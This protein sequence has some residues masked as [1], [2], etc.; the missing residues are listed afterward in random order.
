MDNTNIQRSR[1]LESETRFFQLYILCSFAFSIF[2]L[3]ITVIFPSI[4]LISVFCAISLIALMTGSLILYFY[5]RYHRRPLVVQKTGIKRKLDSSRAQ[6]EAIDSQ[7]RIWEAQKQ[8]ELNVLESNRFN[9]EKK[10]QQKM[11]DLANQRSAIHEEMEQALRD[12]LTTFQQKWLTD[13]LQATKISDAHIPGIGPVLVERLS[14]HGINSANDVDDLRLLNIPGLGE[15]K[16]N[17]VT[18]WRA[19]QQA[20]FW[21][22]RPKSLSPEEKKSIR[23][24]YQDRYSDIEEKEDLEDKSHTTT[25]ETIKSSTNLVL[26]AYGSKME[27]K[28][29]ERK[30]ID[31]SIDSFQK[32]L[33]PFSAITFFNF[34]K[35][36]L[37]FPVIRIGKQSPIFVSNAILLI[38]CVCS[39]SGSALCTTGWNVIESWPT[40]T[41]TSSQTIT[42][43]ITRTFTNTYTLTQTLT[44]TITLTP[45]I[46]FTPSNT[47]TFTVTN[48]PSKTP[49]FTLTPTFTWTPT[50]TRTL[51]AIPSETK[52]STPTLHLCGS[53]CKDGTYSTSTGRGTCSHHGGVARPWYC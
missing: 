18:Q 45:S 43:S 53:I 37:R 16:R 13:S 34:L 3:L 49:T 51:T 29:S 21:R 24:P 12:Q 28:L 2:T 20:E 7:L 44:F 46:T 23:Q 22:N 42:P 27:Q 35:D 6:Q 40:A 30:P 17:D 52:T 15:H 4:F 25:L 31:D 10:H 8:Q 19:S 38:I 26:S 41:L 50:R 1:E 36:V 39:L 14:A 33:I 9:L 48:T 47:F 32:E 5:I 11:F